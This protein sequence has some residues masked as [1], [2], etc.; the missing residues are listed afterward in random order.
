M[1]KPTIVCWG[2][3]VWDLLP[4]GPRLGGALAN[5]AYHLAKLGAHPVLVTRVGDDELG[6]KAVVAL[7]AAGVDVRFVQVD[8]VRPTGTVQV[9]L[10]DGEPRFRIG[11]EAAW[12]AMTLDDALLPVLAAADAVVFG[13]LAQRTSLAEGALV[14]AL[15]VTRGLRVCDLNLRPPHDTFEVMTRILRTTDVVK[16]NEAEAAAVGRAYAVE[17][18]VAELVEHGLV[19]A[20]TRGARGAGLVREDDEADHGGCLAEPGGDNVG[21][22]DAFTAVLTLGLLAGTPPQRLVAQACEYGSFVASQVGA[23][24]EVPE[25]VA[26][27]ARPG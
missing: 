6:R 16:C 15:A 27:A 25:P 11:T 9:T 19:V 23:M 21:C 22:G 13:T 4:S 1:H 18:A 3:L 20:L 8:P 12:D 26:R 5:V 7:A 10:V 24:P 17:D 2:E 14:S